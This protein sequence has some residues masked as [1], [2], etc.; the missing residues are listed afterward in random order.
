MKSNIL[1]ASFCL[2]LGTLPALGEGARFQFT[3]QG[4]IDC[5][6]PVSVHNL[7]VQGQGTATLFPNR[8][9]TMDMTIQGGFSTYQLHLDGRL[10]RRTQA[11]GGM[12]EIHVT[13]PQSLRASWIL[14][15]NDLILDV[16]ANQR[17]CNLSVASRLHRGQRIYTL[18]E[19]SKYYY[20]QQFHITQASCQAY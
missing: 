15:N 5:D 16:V 20:C 9:G 17:S 4:I 19:G 10:G 12:V 2:F 3:W 11:P 8:V 6:Q 13:G 1:A 7:P 18:Y 14:P